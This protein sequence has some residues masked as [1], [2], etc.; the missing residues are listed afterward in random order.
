MTAL[1]CESHR[2]HLSQ[3]IMMIYLDEQRGRSNVLTRRLK[4]MG[5]ICSKSGLTYATACYTLPVVS[6]H[7]ISLLMDINYISL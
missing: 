5:S 3:K 2:R 7:P 1:C 6:M 4:K